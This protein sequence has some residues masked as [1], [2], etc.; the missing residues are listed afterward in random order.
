MM[1]KT[2][3]TKEEEKKKILDETS[4][5]I[6]LTIYISMIPNLIREVDKLKL[7]KLQKSILIQGVLF[8]LNALNP[9]KKQLKE[10]INI[11]EKQEKTI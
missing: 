1:K 10:I 3:L 5:K 4:K 2:V 11:W 7:T 8:P 9:T 6:A